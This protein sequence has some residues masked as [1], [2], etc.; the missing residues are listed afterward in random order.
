MYKISNVTNLAKASFVT[1]YYYKQ[2]AIS[3]YKQFVSKLHDL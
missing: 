2:L 3:T 1:C